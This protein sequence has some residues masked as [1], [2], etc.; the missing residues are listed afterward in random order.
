MVAVPAIS[1]FLLFHFFLTLADGENKKLNVWLECCFPRAPANVSLAWE[2][3]ELCCQPVSLLL[4]SQGLC[5]EALLLAAGL[6][7]PAILYL[8]SFSDS[9]ALALSGPHKLPIHWGRTSRKLTFKM[10]RYTTHLALLP[11]E[12]YIRN[13]GT[14]SLSK[15]NV[16]NIVQKLTIIMKYKIFVPF[17]LAVML[18]SFEDQVSEGLHF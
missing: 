15:S 17:H 18:L 2:G 1:C 4:A 14:F 12:I 13:V 9:A 16:F 3:H 10:Y 8:C 5:A 11:K 6:N 7:P